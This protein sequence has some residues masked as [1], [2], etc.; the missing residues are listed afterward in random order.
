MP[1]GSAPPVVLGT[2]GAETAP[3]RTD[4]PLMRA[5]ICTGYGP[6][7]CSTWRRSSVRARRP[8]SC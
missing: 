3:M 6:Q 2:Q 1:M 8:M 5:A 4:N 7:K